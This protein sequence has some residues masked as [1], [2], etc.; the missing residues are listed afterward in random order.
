LVGD[1]IEAEHVSNSYIRNEQAL[2]VVV[3]GLDNIAVI[4]TDNGFLVTS[5][6]RSQNVGEIAKRLQENDK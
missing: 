3:I 5:K 6:T 2:P 1:K 4:A